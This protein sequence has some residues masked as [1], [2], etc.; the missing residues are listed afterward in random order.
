MS[1]KTRRQFDGKFKS[2][3]VLAALQNQ[4][5]L[6]D[7]CREFDLNPNQIL[8]WKRKVLTAIPDFFD[9]HKNSGK[10]P[11]N[12]ESITLPLNQQISQLKAEL[13]YLK[14]KPIHSK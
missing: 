4:K 3:V 6:K 12:V 1:N 2:Q 13:D 10:K 11:L 7:L 8:D 5:S 9:T 14:K